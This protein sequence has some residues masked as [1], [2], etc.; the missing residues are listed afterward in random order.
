MIGIMAEYGFQLLRIHSTEPQVRAPH[1][2]YSQY[3][4]PNSMDMGSYLGIILGTILNCKRDPYVHCS[5]PL[6]KANID[7][8]S[9]HTAEGA[10]RNRVQRCPLGGVRLG[11]P[12]G[13]HTLGVRSPLKE[14]SKGNYYNY[15]GYYTCC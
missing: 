10:L 2:N 9:R 6:N 1:M 14:V 12:L 13:K 3:L 5:G 7:H 8:G 4:L 15:F 11:G